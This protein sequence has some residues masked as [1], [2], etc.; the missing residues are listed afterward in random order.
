MPYVIRPPYSFCPETSHFHLHRLLHLISFNHPQT[1][2]I[3][4]PPYLLRFQ[5]DVFYFSAEWLGRRTPWSCWCYGEREVVSSIPGRG[6]IVGWVFYPIRW[7]ERF[8][9]IWICLSF[10][11]LNLFR[12]LSSWG[13]INYKPSAPLLYEVASHVKQLPFR[14]LL[15]LLLPILF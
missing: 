7:L 9:L 14:P 8:S 13:S 15:L 2:P 6:N 4:S 11:I 5:C 12:T 10:P 3:P 1:V